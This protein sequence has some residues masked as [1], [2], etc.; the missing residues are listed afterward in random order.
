MKRPSDY[1]AEWDVSEQ[2]E[3]MTFGRMVFA[4]LVYVLSL[5][6]IYGCVLLVWASR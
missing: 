2:D 6:A 1:I 3:E 5:V 4:F